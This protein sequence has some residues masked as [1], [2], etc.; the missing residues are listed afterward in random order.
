MLPSGQDITLVVASGLGTRH[1]TTA[2]TDTDGTTLG[3]RPGITT[4]GTVDTTAPGTTAGTIPGTTDGTTHTMLG[5]GLTT[6][7]TAITD[8]T[9]LT[10]I[11]I[12]MVVAV[13]AE[14]TTTDTLAMLVLS[15]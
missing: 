13:A 5:D 7:T 12:T 6:D 10:T 8:T 15:T 3:I 2:A 14:V 4:R 1:G 11:H 9:R